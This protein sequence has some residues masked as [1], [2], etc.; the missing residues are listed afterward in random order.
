VCESCGWTLKEQY[1]SVQEGGSAHP[2][3]CECGQ[4]M[5]WIVPRPRF[6]VRTDGE[7]KSG[8]TFQKFS[9]RDG[10]NRV[11]E[12]DSLHKLR[13]VERESEKMAADG[14][15][16]PIRFRGY[17]QDH[18]NMAVNTF[19]D[20]PPNELTPEGKRKFGLQGA[21]KH[22]DASEGEPEIAYGPGVNDNNTSAL[23]NV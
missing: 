23:E 4:P 8:N 3:I 1:R 5:I 17:A 20:R 12:I 11:V 19:G 7:G 6:D 2:P 9:I 13:E 16:Q 10:L 15:G 18:S 21:A 22:I 14:I